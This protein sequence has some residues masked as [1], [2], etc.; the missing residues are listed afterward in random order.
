MKQDCSCLCGASRF[1]VNGDAIGRFFCHCTICQKIYRKPFADVTSFWARSISLPDNQGVGFRRY[2]A[3]PAL[4]RGTCGKC[5]NPVV[6]FLTTAPG[7]TVAFVPS[8]NFPR[9][10]ELPEP[11]RHIFY[12]RRVAEIADSIPKLSGYWP[13]Q[14][15]VTRSI[16]SDLFGRRRAA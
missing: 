9:A 8:Q 2:R 7:L 14:A 5:G 16:L 12:H 4:R 13:S 15:Y 11:D 6:G 10:V 1:T 3:P